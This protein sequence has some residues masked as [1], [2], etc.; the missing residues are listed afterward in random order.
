MELDSIVAAAADLVLGACCVGCE[1]PGLALCGRCGQRLGRMPFRT[2]PDPCPAGLPPVW[3]ATTYDDVA[4]AALVA[5]KEDGRTGLGRPLGRALAVAAMG[6]LASVPGPGG[7]VRLVP[8]PSRRAT[9]RARGHEPLLR[10]THEAARALRRAGIPTTVATVLRHRRAVADQAG[11]N[12]AERAANL[13]GAFVVRRRG[14][15]GGADVWL[16]VDDIV[17][18]G[19]TALEAT[20]ALLDAD[21][22]VRGVAVVAATQRHTPPSAATPG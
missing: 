7:A 8:V 17:T 21:I 1:R 13:A 20:R 11:L 22:P 2:W 12:A 14:P 3:A 6:L 9:V 10:M 18:T 4:R 5:H 19:A 16:V 15:T